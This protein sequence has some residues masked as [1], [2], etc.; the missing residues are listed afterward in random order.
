MK[1][2]ARIHR[3]LSCIVA[4]AMLFFAVSAPAVL[5]LLS[6][7][8]KAERLQGEAATWFRIGQ[9][10]LA[11][12]FAATAIAGILMALRLTRPVWLVWACLLIGIAV[13][14]LLALAA[15]R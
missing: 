3:H 2:L 13:P 15:L 4:P 8:H 12:G 9:L 11:A 5:E 7:V 1:R 6:K 14:V 10:V